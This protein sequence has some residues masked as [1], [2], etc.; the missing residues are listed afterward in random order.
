MYV[1]PHVCC[2]YPT[3]NKD[4]YYNYTVYSSQCQCGEGKHT[5]WARKVMPLLKPI[6]N[7]TFNFIKRR[8]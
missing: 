2:D 1:K 8:S 4:S 6:E 5:A 7:E 3:M